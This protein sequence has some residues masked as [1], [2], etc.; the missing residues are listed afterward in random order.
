[1][2]SMEEYKPLN[3]ISIANCFSVTKTSMGITR[4]LMEYLGSPQFI[5]FMMA[6]DGK[7]IAISPAEEDGKKVRYSPYGSAVF[8]DV[9][10]RHAIMNRI[11]RS[12]LPIRFEVECRDGVLIVDLEKWCNGISNTQL[13][14]RK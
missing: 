7:S 3:E 9:A 8:N 12:E 10:V 11:S 13:R 2:I 6:I 14:N 1:M 5:S 4:N